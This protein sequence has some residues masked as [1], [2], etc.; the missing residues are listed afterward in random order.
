MIVY[1]PLYDTYHCIVR[2]LKILN[3]LGHNN[4][5]EDR[6]KIYDYYFLFPCETNN[7]TIPTDYSR[8]KKICTS[9]KYNKVFDTRNTFAQLQSVQETAY[10]AL[11]SFGFID[12]DLLFDNI[13]KLTDKIIPTN[14]LANLTDKE[15]LYMGLVTDYFESLP[16]AELKKRTKLMEYRYEFFE[17]K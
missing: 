3:C 15:R 11:A 7:I 4:R 1:H 5:D 13:I 6:I 16:T 8:Y 9:N 10:R 17:A 14:L 12:N 2:T